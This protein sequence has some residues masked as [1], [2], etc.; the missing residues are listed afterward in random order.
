MWRPR[1]VLGFFFGLG[2]GDVF[3]PCGSRP[4]PFTINPDKNNQNSVFPSRFY[5]FDTNGLECSYK[6]GGGEDAGTFSCTGFKDKVV[7]Q[8][9]PNGQITD[10]SPKNERG[11]GYL[12]LCAWNDDM[13]I[14]S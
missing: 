5:T 1:R 13:I 7:C 4:P 12:G 6:S 11:V 14:G 10:C 2:N 9:V 8:H 3:N